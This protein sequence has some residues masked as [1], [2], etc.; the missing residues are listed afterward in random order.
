MIPLSCCA[1]MNELHRVEESAINS[2]SGD[3]RSVYQTQFDTRVVTKSG[4]S[5]CVLTGS[6]R[7]IY[8]EG[9]DYLTSFEI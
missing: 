3:F 4:G 5:S 2:D 6:T 8:D 9:L 7:I 1:C